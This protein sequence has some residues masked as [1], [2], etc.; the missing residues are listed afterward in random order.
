MTSPLS[1]VRSRR[2]EV[3]ITEARARPTVPTSE[4]RE[5]L[6]FATGATSLGAFLVAQ[7]N[8]GICAILFGRNRGELMCDLHARFPDAELVCNEDDLRD[9]VI[10]VAKMIESPAGN[11][12]LPLDMRG[13]TFQ[14]TVWQA[15]RDIPPGKTASYADVARR[16]GAPKAVRA[17]AQA[18]AANKIAVAIPCHRVVKNDGA[19][20]G[21]R[22]GVERKKALLDKEARP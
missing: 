19:L 18:C 5:I 10:D 22:W 2:G 4:C 7:S 14:K 21:Y 12:A 15:L 17:V 8:D 16:I 20:S 9:L 3:R 6:T 13:T 1:I 11:I